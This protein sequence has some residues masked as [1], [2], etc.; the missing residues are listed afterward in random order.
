MALSLIVDDSSFQRALIRGAI[1]SEGFKIIDANGGAEGLE[2]IASEKPDCI[3]M[4]LL[5]P[6]TNGTELLK[7]IRDKWCTLPIIVLTSASKE[8]T[9]EHRLKLGASEFMNKPLNRDELI[10]A[11]KKA[12]EDR[13]KN[14]MNL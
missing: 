12:L 10:N 1:Q 2:M 5:M 3:V 14:E 11:I 9:R 8:K 6:K 4:D 7:I 13:E